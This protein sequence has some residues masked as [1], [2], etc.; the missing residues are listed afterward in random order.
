MTPGKW[1]TVSLTQ[2]LLPN[3]FQ[4]Q[5]SFDKFITYLK[6]SAFT[7]SDS[8]NHSVNTLVRIAMSSSMRIAQRMGIHNTQIRNRGKII[9]DYFF[10][11]LNGTYA[12]RQS[13]SENL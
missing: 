1:H 6:T 12:K 7:Y 4:S 11:Y 10:H 3:I 8:R 9:Q 13:L 2:S 5:F